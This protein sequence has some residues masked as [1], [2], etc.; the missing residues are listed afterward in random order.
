MF[1]SHLFFAS[2]VIALVLPDLGAGENR[3]F[4]KAPLREVLQQLEQQTGHRLVYD[5]ALLT[6]ATRVSFTAP[7][8]MSADRVFEEVLRAQ[9]LVAITSPKGPWAV[10]PMVDLLGR[11]KATG[12]AMRTFAE[13][14]L[15]IDDA[16][17]VG[18]DLRIPSW[19]AED[20]RRLAYALIDFI[21]VIA[22]HE[23]AGPNRAMRSDGALSDMTRLLQCSD[24]DVHTGA[25]MG[26]ALRFVL[27][28][29]KGGDEFK[30]LLQKGMTDPDPLTR[31]ALLLALDAIN[32]GQDIAHPYRNQAIQ[33][34]HACERFAAILSWA[35]KYAH[36][37]PDSAATDFLKNLPRLRADPSAAVR[38]LSRYLELQL[39]L[40]GKQ[41]KVQA[42]MKAA[43]EGISADK[44]PVL[45]TLLP[46]L[47]TLV[48]AEDY[49]C[50]GQAL[51]LALPD[52]VP[53]E[54]GW[55]KNCREYLAGLEGL[56]KN[57]TAPSLDQ[58]LA[59]TERL[60][61]SKSPA[62][63][64]LP[65][66]A[67]PVAVVYAQAPDAAVPTEPKETRRVDRR[68]KMK[69]IMS[70]AQKRL[71]T[72]G[73]PL[74]HGATIQAI[75]KSES[76]W[77]RALGLSLGSVCGQLRELPGLMDATALQQL[78]LAF[79]QGLSS[80]DEL[81]RAPAC[82]A[83]SALVG[84]A[85]RRN[86]EKIP[87][88]IRQAFQA[89]LQSRRLGE[90]LLIAH[91]WG[92]ALPFDES[93]AI[94]N[95]RMQPG[96]PTTA[97]ATWLSGMLPS[98]LWNK[99]NG[100]T[101]LLPVIDA[102]LATRSPE[103]EHALLSNLSLYGHRNPAAC[104]RLIEGLSPVTLR[105][106]LVDQLCPSE[107]SVVSAALRKRI[108]ALASNSAPGDQEAARSLAAQ[109]GSWLTRS[110]DGSPEQ[111]ETMNWILALL[112]RQFLKA[113]KP[114][115]EAIAFLSAAIHW[116]CEKTSWPE[117]PQTILEATGIALLQ[118]NDPACHAAL[119]DLA[120][121]FD[122]RLHCSNH[123]HRDT[124]KIRGV[125]KHLTDALLAKGRVEVQ[126]QLLMLLAEKDAEWATRLAERL[127]TGKV[128]ET[129]RPQAIKGTEEQ[130][131]AL[132]PAYH[133]F[134]FN[135]LTRDAQVWQPTAY[136]VL[137]RVPGY[138]ERLVN[139]VLNPK[140]PDWNKAG[141]LGSLIGRA[142]MR[143]LPKPLNT[144]LPWVRRIRDFASQTIQQ[145]LAQSEFNGVIQSCNLLTQCGEDP[146]AEQVLIEVI[147]KPEVQRAPHFQDQLT[148]I[149]S[150]LYA[151]APRSN[152][153]TQLLKEGYEALPAPIRL[154]LGKAAARS[155]Q[156]EGASTFLTKVLKDDS[157]I[158]YLKNEHHQLWGLDLQLPATPELVAAFQNL[159]QHLPDEDEPKRALEKL[160][161]KPKDGAQPPPKPPREEEF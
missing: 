113:E 63:Q 132:P 24:A 155:P 118:A 91:T 135:E 128:P 87:P 99:E 85:F 130:A 159:A 157:V 153:Y 141:D 78:E 127:M 28:G 117:L 19:T 54:D 27:W 137:C 48:V 50:R 120:R 115:A 7:E 76:A 101:W 30:A 1:R 42:A 136:H 44:N 124:E 90:N 12:A 17:V 73:N 46:G 56:L 102:V 149:A 33:S 2:L 98:L 59:A 125:Q 126:V 134:L 9:G 13:L 160:G 103:I 86:P 140:T 95:Q 15:K 151:V 18:D 64:L 40:G 16:Q 23:T 10:V 41:G 38:A 21:S 84:N 122:D 139:T 57:P 62:R 5:E 131:T 147:R 114:G 25:F 11:A 129:L 94:L 146:K 72:P 83:A 109:A 69:T 100:R 142:V 158:R 161:V 111:L 58:A 144:Q 77:V 65:V 34:P 47:F 22:W 36:R 81:E 105:S 112:T 156:A 52:L 45:R 148:S 88:E 32:G 123:D 82:L 80:A 55:A 67:L 92:S 3:R 104:V 26:I 35:M 150:L 14:A 96:N 74:I 79:R 20:D 107:D 97:G 68:A 53:G 31:S 70:L 71:A 37:Q 75:L 51:P 108:T 4:E 110:K 106:L 8:G 143:T 61:Q 154:G 93:M 133:E 152:L 116:H 119:L 60:L 49:R 138:E 6:T 89:S 121:A 29:D 39:N 66:L 145:Q 43:L